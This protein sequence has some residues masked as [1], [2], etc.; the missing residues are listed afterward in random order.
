M[1]GVYPIEII[2]LHKSYGRVKALRGLSFRVGEGEIYGLLGPNGAG[3]T[4]TLKILVGLLKPDRGYARIYG[5]DI[6]RHRVD[7]LRHV[8]Y[9]PENP[10]CFQNLTVKEFLYFIGSLRGMPKDE[11]RERVEYYLN[12]FELDEKANA[13]I[14]GLSRG[15]LQK[16]LAS[17]AFLVKPRVLIMDEPMAGMDP[18]A[19]HVFKEEVKKL[20]DNGATALISSH[21]LD[22]VERFCTRVGVINE[23]VLVA[24]GSLEELKARVEAGEESTLEDVFLK[25]IG[26]G[27]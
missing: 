17:A 23:G 6:L 12:V 27:E 1:H 15:M 16:L 5:Y 9:I 18:E 10:V 24:E 14:E 26:E 4:T 20:V 2:D 13:L 8:G 3:K 21:L 25:L 22:M 11:V 7:A 19:Q